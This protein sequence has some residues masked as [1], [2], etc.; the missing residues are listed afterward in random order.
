MDQD[1]FNSQFRKR[2]P[3]GDTH[4]RDVCKDCGFIH[5]ENPKIITGVLSIWEG[6]L[7]LC[8]RAINP[9]KKLLDLSMRLPRKWGND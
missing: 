9:K 8:K 2:T 7:L 1:I 3:A 4:L 6:K 5:Y